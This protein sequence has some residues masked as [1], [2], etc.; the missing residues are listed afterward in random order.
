M[1]KPD[2]SRTAPE[3]VAYIDYLEGRGVS[4][5]QLTLAHVCDVLAEDFEKLAIGE[6]DFKLLSGDDKTFTNLLAVVKN[7]KDFMGL[8]LSLPVAAEKT[9]EE[10]EPETI[11]TTGNN[12]TGNPFEEASKKVKAKINGTR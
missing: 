9:V 7:K 3:V 5:L 10:P 4:K 1:K 12:L 11:K 2:L 8:S 6:T